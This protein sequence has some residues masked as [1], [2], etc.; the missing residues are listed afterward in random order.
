MPP[1]PQPAPTTFRASQQVQ[2]KTSKA[3][4]IGGSLGVCTIIAIIVVSLTLSKNDK[5]SEKPNTPAAQVVTDTPAPGPELTT[6]EIVQNV[7]Q[8]Y[9]SLTDYSAQAKAVC[10]LSVPASETHE[11]AAMS[12]STTS[13]MRLGR[14]NHYRLEWATGSPGKTVEKAMDALGKKLEGAIWSSGQ[15]NFVTYGSDPETKAKSRHDAFGIP[16]KSAFLLGSGIIESIFFSDTNSVIVTANNFTQTNGG[17]LNGAPCYVLA[18]EVKH[19]R[20]VLWVDK[21]TFL[22]DQIEIA[23][24]AKKDEAEQERLKR[25]N[26]KLAMSK[27]KGSV[28]ETFS[29]I[30]TNQNLT[31][32]SF[33]TPFPP[34]AQPTPATFARSERLMTL[35]AGLHYQQGN[36]SLK[37]GLATLTLPDNF[38]YLSPDDADTVLQ[39][40]W[41][42][43]PT[44]TLGLILPS[45][46]DVLS[47]NA[48]AVVIT[49]LGDGYVKDSDAE[50]IDYN[51][52]LN[53]MQDATR[54]ANKLREKKGYPSIDVVGWA[55][56]PHYDKDTHKMYWAKELRFGGAHDTE[57]NYDIRVLG[58]S[59]VLVLNVVAPMSRLAE[60]EQ[61][62]PAVVQMAEFNSGKRYADFNNSTDKVATYGLA[63]L[64][65]G[66]IA[67][68][69]GLF[70][71]LWV[72]LLA[73]KK[74]IVIGFVAIVGFI[75]KLF[76]RKPSP[77]APGIITGGH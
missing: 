40:M 13:S 26:D 12:L 51:Q 42:N 61:Q 14:P 10:N 59:G 20:M 1:V 38:R 31:A 2:Q 50:K 39:R 64:V 34:A 4:I 33:E 6:A 36:I 52:L 54:T 29:D 25:S 67:A 49:Y 19:Q 46:S 73:F 23:L 69:A 37:D 75:K 16:V 56:P 15:D 66:G 76:A 30:R 62:V 47:P 57:L 63:A 17:T 32:S 18:G 24:D 68:K 55:T 72:G 5:Q 35:A 27:L 43:P 44:K 7:G 70:K 9:K 58:R 74:L 65:A 77:P 48:W 53:Q 45:E 28:I 21:N 22:I 41:G 71:V 60:I 11:A 8:A 3:L